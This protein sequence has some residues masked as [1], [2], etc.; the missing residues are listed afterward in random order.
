MAE[1]ERRGDRGIVGVVER[2]RDSR[3]II[4]SESILISPGEHNEKYN[5]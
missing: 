1:V 5:V 2:D 4:R 3:T